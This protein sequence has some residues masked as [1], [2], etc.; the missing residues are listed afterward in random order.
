MEPEIKPSYSYSENQTMQNQIE[1]LQ[2]RLAFQ[3][4][5]ILEM[6]K[7]LVKQQTETNELKIM[8]KHLQKQ[9]RE[10]SP[11]DISGNADERPPHY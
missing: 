11:S 1:E 10:F 3:E 6:S 9:I 2:T 8:V 7:T 5:T 4:D